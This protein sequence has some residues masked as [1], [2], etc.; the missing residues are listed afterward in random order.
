MRL[1]L[2][3]LLVLH[4]L[5]HLLGVAKGFGWAELPALTVPI[6]GFGGVLSGLAAGLL[7][8]TAALVLRAP[9][10]WWVVGLAAAALSQLVVA[11]SWAD[12]R[13]GTL[14]NVVI[15]V[16]AVLT[17]LQSGPTSLQARYRADLAAL[18]AAAPAEPIRAEEL[19]PLPAPIRRYLKAAGVVGTPHVRRFHAELSGR[20]RGAADAPWMPFTAEQSNLVS[21][22]TRLFWMS[23][24][25]GG[26]PVSV[27]HRFRDAAAT[28]RVRLL[29]IAPI[30][31]A[32]GPEMT[33]AETVTVL[34][35]LCVLAPGSLVDAPIRWSAVSNTEAD[36]TYRIGENTVRARLTV[37]EAGRL[38]DFRSE[39]RLRASPDGRS[40]TPAPWRTPFDR[41]GRLGDTTQP[42]HGDARWETPEGDLVYIEM[43]ITK[44]V[45][46]G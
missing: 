32:A 8:T 10:G 37:D 13:W 34:N 38:A 41:H 9:E 15:V 45:I 35:D 18:G 24:T 25:R 33:R 6:S 31:D 30:V 44:V 20:I 7:L 12:A 39:D 40:F 17:A 14:P 16:A 46:N 3:L 1:A 36:A 42:T 29:G 11:E 4:G 19:A 23:A 43:E 21:P 5:L 27:Y 22:P 2:V 26:L 28:M